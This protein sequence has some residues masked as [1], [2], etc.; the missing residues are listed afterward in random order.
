MSDEV[1]SEAYSLGFNIYFNGFLIFEDD[2][3]FNFLAILIWTLL[4]FIV[5]PTPCVVGI[6]MS[7]D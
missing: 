6:L 2:I 4:E 1:L 5:E 7:T 3:Y